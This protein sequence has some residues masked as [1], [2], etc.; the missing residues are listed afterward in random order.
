MDPYSYKKL[1]SEFKPPTP[2][3]RKRP[4]SFDVASTTKKR[5]GGFIPNGDACYVSPAEDDVED[6]CQPLDQSTFLRVSRSVGRVEHQDELDEDDDRGEGPSSTQRLPTLSP[7]QQTKLSHQGQG[8]DAS[9]WKCL[10]RKP[11]TRKNKSWENDAVL[12]VKNQGRLHVLRDVDT[13]KK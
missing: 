6:D 10:Y 3:P 5:L 7:A 4:G 1:T 12:I 11:N 2:K 13:M 8:N 9:Y